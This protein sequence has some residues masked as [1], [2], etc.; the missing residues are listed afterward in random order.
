MLLC[1]L[2]MID[3]PIHPAYELSRHAC[4]LVDS[5]IMATLK[6]C[7]LYVTHN[8]LH[9]NSFG[10]LFMFYIH[11]F[12]LSLLRFW[13]QAFIGRCCPRTSTGRCASIGISSFEAFQSRCLLRSTSCVIKLNSTSV[14]HSKWQENDIRRHWWLMRFSISILLH[15]Q[16]ILL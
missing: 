13:L 16:T 12:N 3:P 6:S 7:I 2:F 8:F 4:R 10:A 5:K 11:P 15:Y 14:Q 1:L 9:F